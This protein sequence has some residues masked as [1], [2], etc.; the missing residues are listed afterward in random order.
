MKSKILYGSS[1]GSPIMFSKSRQKRTSSG[2]KL[3]ALK[4][5]CPPR[6]PKESSRKEV[7][8]FVQA[9]QNSEF[10][11]KAC[12]S[13][14]AFPRI[15]WGRTNEGL[16]GGFVVCFGCWGKAVGVSQRSPQR[17]DAKTFLPTITGNRYRSGG[18][19]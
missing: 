12:G 3:R 14:K 5:R 4:I 9:Q 7:L 10:A 6:H 11:D 19:M 17:S 13:E 16:I 15:S 18:G 8:N 2:E 1:Q